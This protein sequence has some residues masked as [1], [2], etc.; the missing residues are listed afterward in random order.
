MFNG[1]NIRRKLSFFLVFIFTFLFITQISSSWVNA[2]EKPKPEPKDWHVSGI[3]AALDD[4]YEGV[5]ELAFDK[6]GEYELKNLDKQ[7]ADE[8]AKKAAN[9]LENE[10]ADSEFRK[11]AVKA[12]GN[13]GDVAKPYVEDILDIL[14]NEKVD[15]DVRAGAASALG[16]L[17]DAAK[18]Y[19]KDILAFLKDEKVEDYVRNGAA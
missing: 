8:I 5:Q 1:I 7:Q 10:K 14:K 9:V 17:G 11:S 2:K 3:M 18:P 4:S 6:L 16:N 12:L 13:L 19:V 15:D